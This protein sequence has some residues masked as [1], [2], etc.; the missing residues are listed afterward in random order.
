MSTRRRL[1][2]DPAA[3]AHDGQMSGV[4]T[5]SFTMAVQR[6]QRIH[7]FIVQYM[8][9]SILHGCTF[10][11]VGFLNSLEAEIAIKL[12]P[13]QETPCNSPVAIPSRSC[14]TTPRESARRQPPSQ[15]HQCV[16]AFV[17]ALGFSIHFI[18]TLILRFWCQS[19]LSP[20][21][22]GRRSRRQCSTGT[23]HSPS[24]SRWTRPGSSCHYPQ[25]R[26]ISSSH[27]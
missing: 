4:L 13:Q 10:G 27:L 17:L 8:H 1:S 24:A 26:R 23:P 6:L 19:L 21:G 25:S 16:F 11:L 2:P 5:F 20:A 9:R 22:F 3:G 14:K 12:F 18:H 15:S 7:D